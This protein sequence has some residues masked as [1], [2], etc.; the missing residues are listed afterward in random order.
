MNS[1][2]QTNQKKTTPSGFRHR[3][4]WAKRMITP[5]N[6]DEAPEK[7]LELKEKEKLS[8]Q[9]DAGYRLE[10]LRTISLY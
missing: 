3:N 5:Q 2:E 4:V 10:N 6:K 9:D 7:F 1:L 8:P